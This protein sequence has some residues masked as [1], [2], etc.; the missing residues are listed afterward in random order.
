MSVLGKISV[1][2]SDLSTCN[3]GDVYTMVNFEPVEELLECH[4]ALIDRDLVVVGKTFRQ[5][6]H[7]AA[8]NWVEFLRRILFDVIGLTE[9]EQRQREVDKGILKLGDIIKALREL[10]NLVADDTGDH[11]GSGRDGRDDLAGDH[12]RLVAI[13]LLNFIVTSAK[14]RARVYEINVEVLVVILLKVGRDKGVA[15]QR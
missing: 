5:H 12:F 4:R 13:A 11:G 9:K 7:W 1:V 15:R 10:E 8:H 3:H 2:E 14:I 6:R